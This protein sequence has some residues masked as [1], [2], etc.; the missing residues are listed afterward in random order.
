MQPLIANDKA[1]TLRVLSSLLMRR[2]TA[3]NS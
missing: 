3:V 2:G 1:Q